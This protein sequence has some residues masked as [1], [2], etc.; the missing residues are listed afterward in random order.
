MTSKA[1]LPKEPFYL[2]NQS[3]KIPDTKR[4]KASLPKEP[5]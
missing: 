4:S 3:D 1:S 5:F 2:L